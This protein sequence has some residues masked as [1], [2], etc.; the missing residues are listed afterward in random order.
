MSRSVTLAGC[1]RD[2]FD[3]TG[4]RPRNPGGRVL[5]S[6]VREETEWGDPLR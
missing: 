3:H 4:V 6:R 1:G 2:P 5:K